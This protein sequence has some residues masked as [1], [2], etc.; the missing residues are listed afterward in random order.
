MRA[1]FAS[2]TRAR[3]CLNRCSSRFDRHTRHGVASDCL[4]HSSNGRS[5]ADGPREKRREKRYILDARVS[6]R[7][8]LERRPA[9]AQD[10]RP[11]SSS[12]HTPAAAKSSAPAALG[13]PVLERTRAHQSLQLLPSAMISPDRRR[14]QLAECCENVGSRRARTY[15]V[16]K[17]SCLLFHTWMESVA[18]RARLP[19][20]ADHRADALRVRIWARVEQSPTE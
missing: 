16:L 5:D 3:A 12:A 20:P 13:P 8:G 10:G 17:T 19:R 9:G 18:T 1:I 4:R 2:I 11:L 6:A 14:C 7:A 15:R